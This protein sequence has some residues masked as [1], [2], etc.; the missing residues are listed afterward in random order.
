MAPRTVCEIEKVT[1]IKTS[2]AIASAIAR[3][4]RR[5]RSIQNGTLA[6]IKIGASVDVTASQ[7]NGCWAMR[8]NGMTI[9]TGLLITVLIANENTAS[10]ATTRRF[11]RFDVVNFLANI[12]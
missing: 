8:K 4:G 5:R 1:A 3:R 12:T 7:R 9:Q 10:S 11:R 6:A 2:P